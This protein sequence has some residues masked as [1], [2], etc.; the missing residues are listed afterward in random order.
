MTREPLSISIFPAP[1]SCR[2]H[3]PLPQTHIPLP[4]NPA[5]LAPSLHQVRASSLL[6]EPVRTFEKSL[7]FFLF[8]PLM[9]VFK[10]QGTWSSKIRFPYI[11]QGPGISALSPE[12]N[13]H[14]L[15]W[16]W[17]NYWEQWVMGNVNIGQK[18]VMSGRVPGASLTSFI[19]T[20]IIKVT[21]PFGVESPG[22]QGTGEGWELVVSASSLKTNQTNLGSAFSFFFFKLKAQTVH[23]IFMFYDICLP[24]REPRTDNWL[25]FANALAVSWF[26][27]TGWPTSPLPPDP[28]TLQPLSSISTLSIFS[29]LSLDN[30]YVGGE[31]LGWRVATFCWKSEQEIPTFVHPGPTFCL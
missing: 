6:C 12:A 16:S 5:G 24:Q 2:L 3:S 19:F 21:K 20:T 14:E 30:V 29:S 1:S 4:S 27:I 8:F 23:S 31:G 13:W 9:Q 11:L 15:L 10:K 18:L 26:L 28:W 17:R 25:P 22:H 7:A